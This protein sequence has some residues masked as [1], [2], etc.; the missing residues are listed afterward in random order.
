[1]IQSARKQP[2]QIPQTNNNMKHSTLNQS[3]RASAT[4]G[5]TALASLACISLVASAFAQP[6]YSVTDLGVLPG[7]DTSVAV[8]L[9]DRGDVAGYCMNGGDQ[10]AVIWRN[11]QIINLGKLPKGHS[12]SASSINSQGVAIGDGDL[13]DYRPQVW[14]TTSSGLYNFFQAAN[15]HA[16]FITDTGMIGGNYIKGFSGNAWRAALWMQDPKDPRKWQTITLPVISGKDSKNDSTTAWGF[17]QS[18]QA[19]G[20]AVNDIIGQHACFWNND[21][22]HSIVDLGNYPGDWSSIAWGMNNL[23]QVVGESH[24]PAGSRPVL[25]NNNAAHTAIELPLLP[26]DNFG[27]ANAI[28]SLGHVLGSSAYDESGT[29]NVGP[30]RLVIW[31]DGGVFE[32]QSVLDPASGAGWTIATASAIN[33]AGQIVG[34]GVHNGQN[35]AYLLTPI[36]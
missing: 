20:W 14:V 7:C 33:N 31:R 36:Q 19:A 29:W 21:A 11:G 15:S 24:P 13:G 8:G 35:R 6:R 1:V 4:L 27:S 10:V 3:G 32:L 28:N 16:L 23:G 18:G 22:A 5:K 25:W 17:N 26:G 30:A 34:L 9:N 12:A 2:K